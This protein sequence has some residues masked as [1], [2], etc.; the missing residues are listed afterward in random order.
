MKKLLLIIL[1]LSVGVFASSLPSDLSVDLNQGD[2][3]K[4]TIVM[5]CMKPMKPMMP[6]KPMWCSGT[7]TQILRCDQSCNCVW[8]AV[9]LQ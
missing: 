8:E 7:W 6:M 4:D 5:N 3:Y 2:T 9:C 1:I